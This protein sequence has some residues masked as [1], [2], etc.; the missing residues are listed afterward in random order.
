MGM[1]TPHSVVQRTSQGQPTIKEWGREP[2][3][4]GKTAKPH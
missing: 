3:S 4:N 1:L 2:T